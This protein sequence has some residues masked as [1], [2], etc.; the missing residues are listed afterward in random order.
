MLYEELK[1]HYS[2]KNYRHFRTVCFL[3]FFNLYIFFNILM[4]LG[5]MPKNH[6]QA[7]VKIFLK[8]KIWESKLWPEC[9]RQGETAE[10]QPPSPLDHRAVFIDFY[11]VEKTIWIALITLYVNNNKNICLQNCYPLVRCR[12]LYLPFLTLSSYNI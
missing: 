10:S 2:N 12:K 7:H 4:A 9:V 11:G 8:F 3:N 1:F 6:N 5:T